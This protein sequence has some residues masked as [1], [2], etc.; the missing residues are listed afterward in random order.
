[1]TDLPQILPGELGR[2]KEIFLAWFKHFKLS[3]LT[4]LKKV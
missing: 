3:E 1:M 2:T 4:Y